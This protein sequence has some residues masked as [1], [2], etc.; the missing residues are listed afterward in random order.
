MTDTTDLRALAE[1]ATPGPWHVHGQPGRDYGP[2]GRLW[3]LESDAENDIGDVEHT[4]DAAYIAAASPDR[5][6]ALLDERDALLA[7]VDRLSGYWE[8]TPEA[9]AD[10]IKMAYANSARDERARI[11]AAVEALPYEDDHP[12]QVERTAVIDAIEGENR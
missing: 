8:R 2:G 11:R 9:I 10:S 3:W 5:I 1:A 12:Y 6:L 7:E 4:N